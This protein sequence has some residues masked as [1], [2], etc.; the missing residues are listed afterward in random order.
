DWKSNYGTIKMTV[1]EALNESTT[2]K[3]TSKVFGSCG[4]SGKEVITK[5]IIAGR[6]ATVKLN[7]MEKSLQ[8]KLTT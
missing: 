3:T 8:P 4:F 6:T 1:A 5:A 2:I 7:P